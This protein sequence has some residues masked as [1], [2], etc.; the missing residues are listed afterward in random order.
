MSSAAIPGTRFIQQRIARTEDERLLTGRGSFVDD[1]TV[2]GMLHAAFVRSTIAKGRINSIDV[3]EA[4]ASE[5]VVAVYTGA[6]LRSHMLRH[7]YVLGIV[8][9][10]LVKSPAPSLLALDDVRYV[11]DP[12][13]LIVAKDRYLAEDA[14]EKVVV[15]YTPGTPLIDLEDAEGG[16][17]VHPEVPDNVGFRNASPPDPELEAAFANAAHVVTHEIRQQRHLS[18]PMETRGLVA[19]FDPA[20]EGTIWLASQ[21][22]HFARRHICETLGLNE[23]QVRVIAGDVGGGFGLKAFVHRDEFAVIAASRILRRPIKWIEDRT[24]N[25]TFSGQSRDDLARVKLAFDENGL[26][27]AGQFDLIGNS[28]A[29]PLVAPDGEGTFATR[30]FTG[31][32][33]LPRYGWSVL[34]V[35]TNTPGRVAYRG[36]WMVETLARETAMDVAAKQLGIDPLEL[37]RRNILRTADLPYSTAAGMVFDR[38]TPDQTLELAANRVDIA[39]FRR[40][41]AAAREQGRYIGLGISSYIEPSSPSRGIARA[42]VAE[43]RIEPTGDVVAYVSAGSS[44]N[45]IDTTMR[46]VI[47][48]ELSMPLDRISVKFGDTS[49]VGFGAGA[50]GSRQGMV[51]GS[52]VK[53]ASER[54]R[55][56]LFRIA[57]H[58]L[59]TEASR[60]RIEDGMIGE[61]DG[62]NI[63]IG[64]GDLAQIAYFQP[65][66]LPDDTEPGLEVRYRY[67]PPLMTFS[68]ATHMCVVE[69]FRDSGLVK[70]DRWIVGEDCGVLIN[71]QVVEGQVCGGVAQGIGGALLEQVAFDDDGNPQAVS[72]KDYLMP[73]ISDMPSFEFEHLCTPSDSPLGA[74]GV[75]EGGAIV[76]PAAVINAV[77]DALAPF[78]ASFNRLPLSPSRVLAA[79]E[80]GV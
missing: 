55:E 78:G 38:I 48:E 12:I 69:V 24:E 15:D 18:A 56:K 73:A 49:Q 66:N 37:R 79:I 57:A 34:A 3:S 44:G 11:G 58:V 21:N 72:F 75:G 20:G 2:A 4:A 52:A 39:R 74:K 53:V 8:F 47:A 33:R 29:Y 35:Y 10:D 25:L 76:A 80:A 1:V 68:N 27:L 62:S 19:S 77:T 60:L 61:G 36:P 50:G 22:V 6:D 7:S 67:A 45:S 23:A 9:T 41:Q 28:G 31:P 64:L 70:V 46:Q 43:L 30:V 59:G 63:H 17:Q 14:A 13:A 71:P 5:G 26:L 32:Y 51:I 40:E 42:D 16:A 54:M 65:E